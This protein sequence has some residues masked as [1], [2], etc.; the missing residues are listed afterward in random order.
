MVPGT[1][2][3]RRAVL[4][5]ISTLLVGGCL[6]RSPPSSGTDDWRMYGRDPGRTRYVSD[7]EIPETEPEIAWERSVGASGWRPPIVVGETVYCQYA[8]G[9]FVLEATTGEGPLARTSGAFGRGTGPMVFAS[10]EIYRDGTLVVPY[11]EAIAGYTGAPGRW[12]DRVSGF[13]SELLR[14][15][16]D[17]EH[18]GTGGA[19]IA[20]RSGESRSIASPLVT[21]GALVTVHSFSDSVSAVRPDDGNP[22]WRYALE[23]AIPDDWDY[24]LFS[25]GHVVDETTGTVVVKGRLFGTPYLIGL[26][27][28]DGE[29]EWTVDERETSAELNEREDSL[30][31]REGVVYTVGQTEDRDRRILEIDAE[32]GERGW[33]RALDRSDHVGLA[34]DERTLYH[35]GTVAR[36]GTDPLAVTALD[37]DDG[38]VRWEVIF[39][40]D[41]F[42]TTS[43]SFQPPTVAGDSL[44]VPGDD[45]LHALDCE[46]GDLLW[47]FTEM[48][49]TSGGS[50]T[51][52][53]ALTPA[54]VTNDRIVLGT[55]LALYGLDIS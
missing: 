5:G 47:T 33:N 39:D 16:S 10:T 31:A 14:W 46:S 23:D 2:S 18:V 11:G 8:N 27:L 15:W 3:S 40:G 12:P 6:G 1:H 21:D 44:L 42:A 24:G 41:S 19:G 37:L 36:D 26:D 52:R 7:V 20:L 45:G 32:T 35:V 9:L 30:L 28:A 25:I 43:F 54:V 53:E 22:R 48:V 29:L 55:T 34:A 49:G 51:E 38:S 50:E 4:G 17:G 13:G